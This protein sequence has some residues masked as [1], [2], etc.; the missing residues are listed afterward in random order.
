MNVPG[1]CVQVKQVA[2]TSLRL[3]RRVV[4]QS[5]RDKL[6]LSPPSRLTVTNAATM[7]TATTMEM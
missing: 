4:G 5:G 3:L 1:F 2:M 7:Q 6:T